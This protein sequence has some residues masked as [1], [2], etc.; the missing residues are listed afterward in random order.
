MR[1]RPT[2]APMAAAV[3]L[4][5]GLAGPAASGGFARAGASAANV[6]ASAS[7]VPPVVACGQLATA[8][9]DFSKVPDAPT[10][11]ISAAEVQFNGASY[12]RVYGYIAPQ[13]QLQLLLPVST[14]TGRYVQE[15][16]DGFCSG[17]RNDIPPLGGS[18]PR[19]TGKLIIWQG[20]ADE[21]ISP[22]GTVDYYKAV[23]QDAGGFRASQNF[24]RLYMIPGQ[25]HCLTGGSPPVTDNPDLLGPLMRWAERG[26]PPG[27]I[28]FPLVHPTATMRA[29]AVHPLN[30]LTPPPGG[31]RGL[32]TRYHW[33]GR[34]RPGDE[35]WCRTRGMHLAC[36]HYRSAPAIR[37]RPQ[38]QGTEPSD[39]QS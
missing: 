5:A 21:S 12:C 1:K 30:P 9:H 36:T 26:I 10:A 33:I 8:S 27:T 23:V 24:S 20:W 22:F 16:C 37:P 39:W 4:A 2:L 15:G 35:L 31:T 38:H 32:N 3:L 17:I 28:T 6:A 11:V 34:F 29:I 19:V 25:Y 14:Y 7:P 18:C 13:D